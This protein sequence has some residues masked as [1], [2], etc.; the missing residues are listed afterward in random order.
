MNATPHVAQN[1]NGRSSAIDGR[2]TGIFGYALSQR[3]RKADRGSLRLDQDDGRPG[4]NQVS[5]A[6]SASDGP[7]P[8]PPA[9][10]PKLMEASA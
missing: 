8:S 9:R 2:T 4:A 5:A 6:G 7:S 1:T 3:V 10:L